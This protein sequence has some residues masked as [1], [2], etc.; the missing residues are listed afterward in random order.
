MKLKKKRK[1]KRMRG[2]GMGTHGWGARKKHISSGNR[3]GFGMSGT[4]KMAGHKKTYV[5]KLYGTS[6]F[7]KQG[8]TSRST[9]RRANEVMN[10]A[11]IEENF[12]D[13]K[14]KFGKKDG[15]LDLKDYKILGD[16]E[17]KTKIII[18]AKS[19]SKS[20]KEKIEKAGG[21]VIVPGEAEEPKEEKE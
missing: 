9:E 14:A 15:S 21:K 11:Y 7:G 16:G 1:M 12:D 2:H 5:T 20:A 4:G 6:Y 10:V 13:L 8:V 3:G 19:C 18:N 17:I